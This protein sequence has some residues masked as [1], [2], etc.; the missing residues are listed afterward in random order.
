MA[1][2]A[3]TGQP[4]FHGST[5]VG[6]R[7]VGSYQVSGHPWVTGS[8]SDE[9]DAN[10]TVMHEFPYVSKSVTVINTNTGGGEDLRVHFQSGSTA[11]ITISGAGGMDP[12]STNTDT[13][14]G[15]VHKGRH[16]MTVKADSALTLDVKCSKVYIT[17]PAGGTANLQYEVLAELTLIPTGSM[18]HLT[19]S[20]VTDLGG[21]G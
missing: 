6:L 7:N 18:Y 19:G 13:S 2:D 20:G 14:K 9:L 16:Y 15:D 4:I 1:T 17:N 21:F 10:Q 5:R 3:I 8:Q 11:A 12:G